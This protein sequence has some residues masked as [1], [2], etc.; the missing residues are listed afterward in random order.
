MSH[1]ADDTLQA[2]REAIGR[3]AW[4]EAYDLLD[5][6]DTAGRLSPEDLETLSAAAWWTG[7]LDSCIAA[8]ERAFAGY[9]DAESRRRAAIVAL[10]VAKDYYAKHSSSIANAWV[11]R[12]KRLLA[13]EPACVEQGY[14]ERLLSVIA[15]EGDGDFDAALTH[16]QRALETGTHF[17]D[18]ELQ[19]LAL[20]DQGR[21][22][23]AKGDVAEGMAMIDEATVAAVSGELSPYNT[24]VIYCNTITA[25]K[26]LADYR[27][28]GDWTEAAKR[29]CERQAIAG[30]PGMC[31]VY[32]ASIMLVRGA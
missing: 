21:V 28:A 11:A 27:R 6:A 17:G 24:G 26:E 31:R 20:H 2:G 22:L 3:H 32:R 13:D 18:R 5:A 23:V 19:A 7:R 14:L 15:F 9:M 1:T 25:C 29:W 4:L 8:R 10:A 16:A 12:A 30:F